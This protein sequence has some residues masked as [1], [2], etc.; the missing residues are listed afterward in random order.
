MVASGKKGPGE[1][2]EEPKTPKI[3]CMCWCASTLEQLDTT[4]SK[5]NGIKCSGMLQDLWSR[6]RNMFV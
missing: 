6:I 5:N 2:V 3:L 1:G 4:D